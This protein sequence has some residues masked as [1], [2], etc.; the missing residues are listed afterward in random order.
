MENLKYNLDKEYLVELYSNIIAR[1]VDERT[2]DKVHPSFIS[3]IKDLSFNDIKFL[4]ALYKYQ[5]N[6]HS[7]IP[8]ISLTIESNNEKMNKDFKGKRYFI[9]LENYTYKFDELGVIIENLQKLNLISIDF[10]Q[11][12]KDK[13]HKPIL[14]IVF[15]IQF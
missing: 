8:I 14:F 3:I 5:N 2:K 7:F 15:F 6:D 1:N 4:E 10:M 13:L 12:L 11:F 9:L